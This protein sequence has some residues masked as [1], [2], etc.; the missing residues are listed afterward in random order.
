VTSDHGEELFEHGGFSH[1]Y[2]LHQETLHVPLLIK[3]PDVTEPLRVKERVSSM[4][5]LPTVLDYLGLPVPE[6]LD[7]RSLIPLLRAERPE[8]EP[9]SRTH[10]FNV[11]WDK[12]C[13]ASAILKWPWKLI[14]VESNYEGLTE[15]YLLYRLDRDPKETLN[16]SD[17]EPAR[18]QRM[19]AELVEA[20]AQYESEGLPEPEN[21]EHLMDPA[22]LRALGYAGDS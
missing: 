13:V 21:V 10:Y 6:G 20:M 4:D 9:G 12:R 5:V 2:S 11:R 16:L 19:A 22:I 8:E 17:S 15:E 1:G 14:H 18:V 3:V 7:G